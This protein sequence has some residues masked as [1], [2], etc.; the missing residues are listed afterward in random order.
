[1]SLT[2]EAP[3]AGVR[4]IEV[5][6]W[7]AAPGAAAMMSD[8]GADVVKVEPLRGDPMRGVVRQPEVDPP[9]DAP[10]QLDNRGK[11]G[12]AVALD[13]PQGQELVR[14]LVDGADVFLCNLLG[15]TSDNGALCPTLSGLVGALPPPPL[16]R[17][18]ASSTVPGPENVHGSLSEM[19]AVQ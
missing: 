7:M 12:I 10:F 2:P 4:V 19:L 1:M 8:L 15:E 11:R 14:R 18:A 16:P 17:T 6:G 13:R 9:L 5:A 3:L